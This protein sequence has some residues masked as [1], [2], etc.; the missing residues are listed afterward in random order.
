MPLR[1]SLAAILRTVR[2]AR[3]LN[4]DEFKDAVTA[5]HLHLLE[6]GK[7]SVTL[8][9]LEEISEV[10]KIDPLTLLILA[11]GIEKNL[12]RAELFQDLNEQLDELEALGVMETVKAHY[13]GGK[14]IPGK[15]GK[16]TSTERLNAIRECKAAGMTQKATSQA[17]GI[18]QSTVHDLW[19]RVD[20]L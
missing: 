12:P 13:Q 16:S 9:T 19:K 6:N 15:A 18:P 20:E 4:Q 11:S 5:K 17:L 2:L 3:G 10:L 1:Q 8:D 14:L 7:H